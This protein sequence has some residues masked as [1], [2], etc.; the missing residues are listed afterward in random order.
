MS[1]PCAQRNEL[2]VC[3]FRNSSYSSADEEYF[4]SR[5]ADMELEAAQQEKDALATYGMLEGLD[6]RVSPL[7]RALA[8]SSTRRGEG[9]AASQAST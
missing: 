4:A 8:S 6:P 3:Y 5:V 2:G 7:H 9:M 1:L